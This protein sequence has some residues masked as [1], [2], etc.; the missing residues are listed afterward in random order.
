MSKR[1]K[2]A[3]GGR[4]AGDPSLVADLA[5]GRPTASLAAETGLSER[6]IRR[7]RQDPE[8]VAARAALA[9]RVL[10]QLAA[11]ATK[12]VRT[13]DGLLECPNPS[14]AVSAARTILQGLLSMREHDELTGRIEALETALER[15]AAG[16]GS[17]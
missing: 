10:D 15:A 9:D 4:S 17:P 11:S 1:P 5:A 3:V 8:V 13:L 14:V 12:A 2:P 7:R 16:G 6:T